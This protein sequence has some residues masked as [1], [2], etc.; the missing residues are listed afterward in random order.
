[1]G[2]SV[3]VGGRGG[4]VCVGVC[5]GG[6]GDGGRGTLDVASSNAGSLSISLSLSL[7]LSL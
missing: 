1:M 3:C 4:F 7:S 5:V 2:E 6:M